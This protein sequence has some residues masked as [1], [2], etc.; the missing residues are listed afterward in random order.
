MIKV[1]NSPAELFVGWYTFRG[2]SCWVYLGKT[3]KPFFG[4]QLFRFLVVEKDYQPHSEFL[5]EK[6]VMDY[7]FSPVH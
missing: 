3:H 1:V 5:S 7:V 6:G 4:N 2:D